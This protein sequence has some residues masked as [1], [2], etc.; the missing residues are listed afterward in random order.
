[1]TELPRL[2]KTLGCSLVHLSYPVPVFSS[3]FSVP[4]VVTLHDLY[5]FEIPENFGYPQVYLNQAFTRLCLAN[6]NGLTCISGYTFEQ[7]RKYFPDNRKLSTIIYHTVDFKEDE[8]RKPLRLMPDDTFV[9]AV[10]QHRKNKNLDI[11]IR[12]FSKLKKGGQT[13]TPASLL[14]IVGSQDSETNFL[15]QLANELGIS[16]QVLFLS[17]LADAELAWLFEHCRLLVLPSSVEGLGLPVIEGLHYNCRVICSD[18]P[19]L[20]EVGGEQCDFFSLEG[21]AVTNLE[22]TLTRVWNS[23]RRIHKED[24]RFDKRAISDQYISFYKSLVTAQTSGQLSEL[25]PI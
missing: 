1:M 18:I 3:L 5:P 19:T 15:V 8:P 11:L 4:I 6:C 16:D 24:L 14:V 13:T 21:D 2:A 10:A 20:R 12:A 9:L 23:P 7:F 17:S 25:L 22:R